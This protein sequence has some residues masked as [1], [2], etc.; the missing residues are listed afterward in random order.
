M[1]NRVQVLM[2]TGVHYMVGIFLAPDDE[3]ECDKG[4]QKLFNRV[5]ILWG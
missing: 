3:S 2:D 1:E 4:V 5:A